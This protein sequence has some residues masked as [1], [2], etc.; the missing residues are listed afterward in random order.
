LQKKADL[1][2]SVAVLLLLAWMVW[3]AMGWQ[4][5]ASLFPFTVGLPALALALLQCTFAVRKLRQKAAGPAGETFQTRLLQLSQPD[6]HD[7]GAGAVASAIDSAYGPGSEASEALEIDPAVARRRTIEMSVW[8]LAFTA[9]VVLLGF[10]VSAALLPFLFMRI[11]ARERW[12]P[13][14]LLGIGTYLVFYWIFVAGL[15]LVLPGGTIAD[16]L[17][18]ESFDSYLVDPIGVAIGGLLGR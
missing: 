5:T 6:Y 2:F 9:A 3:Q 12:L 8:I 13:S 11:A 4:V 1:A 17:G 18:L 14:I 15:H 10:R 7:A 16:A